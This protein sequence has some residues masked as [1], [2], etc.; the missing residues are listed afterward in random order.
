MEKKAMPSFRKKAELRGKDVFLPRIGRLREGAIYEGAEYR[1]FCPQFLEEIV[2]EL[3]PVLFTQ[4]PA[5]VQELVVP[6]TPVVPVQEPEMPV[7][8]PAPAAESAMVAAMPEVLVPTPVL[9][10]SKPV[11]QE[12]KEEEDPKTL[13][14]QALRKKGHDK[15][16]KKF[17]A[18]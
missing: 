6:A 9:E 16:S 1:Q 7:Q 8:E 13:A 14:E 10:P 12:P 18:D 15:P 3:A 17:A 11:V 5:P 4:A 2:Q